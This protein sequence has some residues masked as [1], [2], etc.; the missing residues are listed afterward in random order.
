ME[1][2]CRQPEVSW[3]EMGAISRGWESVR[4]EAGILAGEMGTHRVSLGAMDVAPLGPDHA[5][6]VAPLM[7]DRAAADGNAPMRGAMTLVAER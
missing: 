1:V 5:L 2:F 7:I 4:S 6:V 3:V